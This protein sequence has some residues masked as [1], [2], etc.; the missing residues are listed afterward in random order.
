MDHN[1]QRK[2]LSKLSSRAEQI[3]PARGTVCGVEGPAVTSFFPKAGSSTRKKI[4]QADLLVWS[5]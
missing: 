4:G 2:G 1:P 3:V 5:E